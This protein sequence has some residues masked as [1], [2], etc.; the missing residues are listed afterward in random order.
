M[1]TGSD[2]RWRRTVR[3]RRS[4]EVPTT[5]NRVLVLT[6]PVMPPRLGSDP[7]S[8]DGETSAILALTVELDELASDAAS[9]RIG[10]SG[11]LEVLDRAGTR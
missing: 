1:R 7:L 9:R 3:A 6:Q 2:P 4:S 10:R 5:A 8:D 11:Y